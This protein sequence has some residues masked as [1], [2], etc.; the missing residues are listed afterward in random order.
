MLALTNKDLL[1]SACLLENKIHPPFFS[2]DDF[3]GS[4]VQFICA[5]Q[6]KVH[7]YGHGGQC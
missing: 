5:F 3:N 2:Q 1:C 4:V 6:F 7:F